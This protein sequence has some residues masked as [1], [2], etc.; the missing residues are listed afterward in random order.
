MSDFLGKYK[1]NYE[2][3]Q[4]LNETNISK[5]Y[6]AFNILEKRKCI[7]KVINKQILELGDYDSLLEK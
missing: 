4:F 2:D 1:N 7:L 5:I 6:K 3:I